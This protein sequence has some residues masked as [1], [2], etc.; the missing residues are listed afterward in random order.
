MTDVEQPEAKGYQE[1]FEERFGGESPLDQEFA[2]PP[3]RA[4][5]HAEGVFYRGPWTMEFDGFNGH[6]RRCAYALSLTGL[7]VHLQESRPTMPEDPPETV[8]PYSPFDPRIEKLSEC[9]FSKQMVAIHQVVLDDSLANNLISHASY[10]FVLMSKLNRLK[11]ISTVFERD[12]LSVAIKKALNAVG[13]VWVACHDNRRMLERNGVSKERITVVPLPFF[14][15][16]PVAEFRAQERR[17]GPPRFY[18][19]GKWE[20][21]KSQNLMLE[22]FL[23]AFKPGEAKFVL[24][25]SPFYRGNDDFPVSVGDCLRVLLGRNEVQANG[26][27]AETVKKWVEVVDAYVDASVIHKLHGFGDVYVT[28]SRGEGFDMPA[29]DARLAGR[30]VI[31]TPTGAPLD[32]HEEGIDINVQPTGLRP[33][34]DAYR[35]WGSGCTYFELSVKPLVE[36]YREMAASFTRRRAALLESYASSGFMASYAAPAVGTTMRKSVEDV[37]ARARE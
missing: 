21:R 14:D 4:A 9:S 15:D 26:W 27:T 18:H 6:V 10:D 19:I 28:Y 37:M 12:G 23:L 17:P 22:A 20:P 11:I 29:Y 7:P 24:K 30:P 36:A 16:E 13:H 5:E 33:V 25:T 31:H 1:V 3:G 32:L 34:H 8:F 35:H 2:P